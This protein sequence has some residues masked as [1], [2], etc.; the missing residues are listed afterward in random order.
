[1]ARY[2]RYPDVIGSCDYCHHWL[3]E[4]DQYSELE[5]ADELFIDGLICAQC[6]CEQ[7]VTGP[8]TG[9]DRE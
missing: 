4:D 8:E 2:P 1:M 9:I 6:E 7:L 5:P 3:Y